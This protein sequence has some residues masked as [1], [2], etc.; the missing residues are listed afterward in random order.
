[1]DLALN[2]IL[3][4]VVFAL[5]TVLLFIAWQRKWLSNEVLS[6][7]AAIATIVAFIGFLAFQLPDNVRPPTSTS[8]SFEPPT[9]TAGVPP[10]V[11]TGFLTMSPPPT[12]PSP[13]SIASETELTGCVITINAPQ[14]TLLT[15]PKLDASP[16]GELAKGSYVATRRS[17]DPFQG[18]YFYVVQ[19]D[20]PEGWVLN[21]P[22]SRFMSV[23]PECAP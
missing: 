17:D 22:N 12:Y 4:V 19:K 1:M 6:A 16:L 23:T 18:V 10:E 13:S 3:Y 7:G 5:I 21:I 8:P 15:R 11:P 9:P 14:V 2:Q 20:G